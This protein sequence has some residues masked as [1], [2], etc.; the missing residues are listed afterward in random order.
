MVLGTVRV[1]AVA[2]KSNIS[3]DSIFTPLGQGLWEC[4]PHAISKLL[5]VT[6]SIKVPTRYMWM[7]HSKRQVAALSTAKNG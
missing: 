7:V 2:E 3:T 6:G 4:L 1:S 5:G